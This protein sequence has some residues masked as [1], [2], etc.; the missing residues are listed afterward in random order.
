M[1]A[2]QVAVNEV[3]DGMNR[4][5]NGKQFLDTHQ[6]LMIHNRIIKI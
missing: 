6:K 4:T 1:F 3:A 2:P 5:A